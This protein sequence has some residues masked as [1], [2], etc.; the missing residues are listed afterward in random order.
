M[1]KTTLLWI[2]FHLLVAI[3]LWVDLRFLNQKEHRLSFKKACILSGFG[4][5][6]ALAFNLFIYF[7]LGSEKALQFLAGY[8]VEK[9]LSV[10]NLFLF[11]LIFSQFQVSE[12]GQRKVLSWGILG[13]I[14][15][16][17]SLILAGISLIDHFHWMLYVFGAFLLASGIKMFFER[18]KPQKLSE[19]FLFRALKRVLPMAKEEGKQHFFVRERGKWKVTTLFIT[20]LMIESTD[21]IMALDSIPAIF[22]IT[23]DPFLVYTSN[24]FAI[25]GLRALYFVLASGLKKWRY[26]KYGLAGIL[27][28]VGMKM[29]TE[30]LMPISL[31]V[32]LGVILGILAITMFSS[33]KWQKG[34]N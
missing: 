2:C 22:A 28:F 24:V 30:T 7:Q 4:I 32:S 23:T 11:L 6:I 33:L 10:D 16:R 18:H 27:I 13:A 12:A 3:L 8:V 14:V 20:L 9:S 26:L 5:A 34:A 15:L 17:L 21:L 29:L 19:N 1:E 25:L 31:P